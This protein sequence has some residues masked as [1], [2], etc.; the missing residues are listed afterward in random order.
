MDLDSGVR[1]T[2]KVQ[3]KFDVVEM[4]V[5]LDTD[6][7]NEK[8]NNRDMDKFVSFIRKTL[9]AADVPKNIVDKVIF[10]TPDNIAKLNLLE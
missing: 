7:R 1:I 3:N 8:Y 5:W 2:I 6:E 4:S 10:A 9:T